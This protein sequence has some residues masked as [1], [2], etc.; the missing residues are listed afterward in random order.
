MN[1]PATASFRSSFRDNAVRPFAAWQ[2]AGLLAIFASLIAMRLPHAWHGRF[3]GEEGT[4]FFAYAWHS[5]A[6][7]ALL[8]P[9][10]GYLNLAANG[11]TLLAA[12][13]V[14]ANL[15]SLENAPYLTMLAGLACQMIPVLVLLTG[16][17][18]WLERKD[19]V[20]VALFLLV[21]PPMTEEVFL[22]VLHIQ[23][24]LTLA[25][26]LILS[27]E[28]PGARLPR[29]GYGLVLFIAPLCGPGA[30]I[31]V[32]LFLLRALVDRTAGRIVQASL[33][34]AGAAIQLVFFFV[35]SPVRQAHFD[36][37]TLAAILFTRLMALPLLGPGL[38]NSVG[39]AVYA[40]YATGGY[41]WWCAAAAA[42]LGSGALAIL[43]FRRGR[44][45]AVW[46]IGSGGL[47]AAVTFG[48]GMI[49]G[50]VRACFS[51]SSG[52]RYDY[53]PLALLGVGI[54]ALRDRLQGRLRQ[55]FTGICVLALVQGAAAYPRPIPGLSE[56]VLWSKEVA[57]WR[58]NHD[59]RLV[60]WPG[61]WTVDLS[62]HDEACLP[63]SAPTARAASY[64]EQSWRVHVESDRRAA[65]ERT[66]VATA[67]ASPLRHRANLP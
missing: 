58:L 13:L 43:A 9:F 2:C 46:L 59:Y 39:T 6:I 41:G 24:H 32:P 1:I 48:G 44:N 3:L 28:V 8:R 15:L 55:L 53:L 18:A 25:A 49:N 35:A 10:G 62:D 7:D 22:N 45:A 42:I 33:L 38:A 67:T 21:L 50:G 23:F 63:S 66:G 4:I 36:A 60:E 29:I 64:C 12:R 56:G 16:K 17:S 27:V 52:E 31:L 11:V 51:V 37:A 30:I 57:K 65:E 26:A 14:Q 54:V 47:I 40:S 19:A 61:A 34:T 20:V 5:S